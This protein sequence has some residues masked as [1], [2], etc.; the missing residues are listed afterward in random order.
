MCRLLGAISTTR[1]DVVDPH[2]VQMMRDVMAA[3]DTAGRLGG[4]QG[5]ARG[6]EYWRGGRWRG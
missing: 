4:G 3:V 2:L 5:G 6:S 1:L